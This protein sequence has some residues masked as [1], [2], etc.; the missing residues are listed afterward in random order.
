MNIDLHHD[1]NTEVAF[2]VALIDSDTT[3]A[4]NIIDTKDYHSLEFILFTSTVSDGDYAPKVE[5]GDDPA[6]SDAA[7][8][9]SDFLLGTVAE[10]SFTA[11]TDDNK[12]RR[13]GYV[14]KK[15]YVRL[16]IVSTDTSSGAT[17]GAVA[18]KYLPIHAP[19]SAD[20]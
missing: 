19:T 8:V 13:I 4:G 12:T 3:T 17:L 14:G 6:L 18:V 16:S 10:A 20:V 5:D 9:D 2:D 15:R 11:D 7:E 1:I